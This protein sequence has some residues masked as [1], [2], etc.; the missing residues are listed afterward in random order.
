MSQPVASETLRLDELLRSCIHCGLCLGSCPTYIV[1]G[2]EADSPRGRLMVMAEVSTV[3]EVY[4]RAHG[5]S[6][7]ETSAPAREGLD[8]CL[9]CRNCETVCPSGVLYG[10][11]LENSRE[12]LGP[13]SNLHARL[14]IQL[15]DRVMSRPSVLAPAAMMARVLR[16]LPLL[17]NVAPPLGRLLASL[18]ARAPSR[19]PK[20]ELPERGDVALLAGCAQQV[21]GPKVLPATAALVQAAGFQACLPRGQN[22]CGA[23]SHHAGSVE[24]GKALARGLIDALC[25]QETIVVPSA[26]CSAHMREYGR[27]FADEPA[28]AE[29]ARKVADATVDLVV[30][31]DEKR[32]S[33]HFQAD[34]RRIAYH[35]P[36]HHTNAQGI[37][38]E[39][40][41][42]LQQVPELTVL[43]ALDAQSCCG[44]AGAFSLLQPE[45]AGRVREQKLDSLKETGA[46]LIVTANPGCELFLE[47]GLRERRDRAE[48][49]HLAVYLAGLLSR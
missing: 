49:V 9:G 39:P 44:S 7:L 2:D 22:C 37:V 12:T 42:L 20:V 30:W 36:C 45:M 17:G 19:P 21:F 25:E 15:V 35:P 27:I 8:R 28:Y 32:E 31:L 1:S 34:S 40:L 23:L 5:E 14:A 48:V 13:P 29:K 11:L 10:E 18:P 33:L 26:G 3:E 16:K 41:R 46:E 47:S 6:P 43:Q 38:D 24:H 4:S